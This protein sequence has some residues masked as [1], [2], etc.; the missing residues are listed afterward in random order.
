MY[1]NI[2][3]RKILHLLKCFSEVNI[4]RIL[5]ANIKNE[6]WIYLVSYMLQ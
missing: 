1:I 2:R 5:K 4:V 6:K 3:N